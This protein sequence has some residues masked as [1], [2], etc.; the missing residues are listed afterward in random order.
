MSKKRFANRND[1]N[2]GKVIE[3]LLQIPGMTVIK[4]MDDFLLGFVGFTF[5]VELKNPERIAKNKKAVD[6]LEESQV[7]INNSFNG[8]YIVA[9]SSNEIIEYVIGFFGRF[10]QLDYVSKNLKRFLK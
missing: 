4:D 8:A 6:Y 2:Q 1:N 7:K 10:K 5:L 9:K 3:D